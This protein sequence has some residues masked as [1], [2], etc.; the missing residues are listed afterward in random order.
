MIITPS[1]AGIGSAQ[2]D[3]L[4]ADAV[5]SAIVATLDAA[6]ATRSGSGPDPTPVTPVIAAINIP[7]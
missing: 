1:V 4:I 2:T 3:R 6:S 5:A 7:S